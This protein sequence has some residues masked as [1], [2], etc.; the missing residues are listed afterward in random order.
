MKSILS[1]VE[2]TVE[3]KRSTF[4]TILYPVKFVKDVEHALA[5]V[6]KQYPD[7][8]H[9][10]YAYI[11][12]ENQEIQKY[13]DDGEP[14]QTAGMPILEVLKK[15]DLTNVLAIVVRYF[16]GI[17]LGAGGLIRAYSKGPAEAIKKAKLASR[18]TMMLIEIKA[19]FD[20][21]GK[22]EPFV[23]EIG[24][25]KDTVY[26]EYVVYYVEIKAD[27]LDTITPKIRDLSQGDSY[28]EVVQTYTT[29]R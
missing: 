19:K 21:I 9:H 11:I 7:A 8:N 22:F 13:E 4:H 12:G 6:K 18:E 5:A 20:D 17:K 24:V 15:N 29:Y 26:K 2:D 10:C 1:V 3:I 28:P 27:Q 14:S 25:L 23:R 16:G